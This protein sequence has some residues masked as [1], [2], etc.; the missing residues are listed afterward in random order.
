MNCK[1]KITV[2]YNRL[3]LHLSTLASCVS[4]TTGFI[5]SY[6][7]ETVTLSI[8]IVWDQR[9]L[10]I[11]QSTEAEEDV[12]AE[13]LT[14]QPN[15]KRVKELI[16]NKFRKCIMLKDISNLKAKVKE[17]T[18]KGLEE[19]AYDTSRRHCRECSGRHSGK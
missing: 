7:L 3:A 4:N 12:I 11:I 16:K 2:S 1:V 8:A 18:R 19:P 5:K 9:Y 10:H 14:V 17:C 6:V 13:L 15:A